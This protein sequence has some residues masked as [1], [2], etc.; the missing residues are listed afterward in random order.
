[1]LVSALVIFVLSL[2]LTGL[3]FAVKFA[4]ERRG[5]VMLPHLRAQA[6]ARALELKD[7]MSRSR[8]EFAKILPALILILRYGIHEIALLLAALG[9]LLE[10]QSHKLADTVSHKHR[11]ERRESRSEFL[12]K[13]GDRKNDRVE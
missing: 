3:L 9:R 2:T 10:R 8:F 11:F 12:K 1:M 5:V 7:F 4:E 13:I 6:D